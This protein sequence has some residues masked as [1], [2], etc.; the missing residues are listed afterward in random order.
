MQTKLFNFGQSIFFLFIDNSSCLMLFDTLAGYM[1]ADQG[2]D[3]WLANS[4][5]NTYSRSHLNLSSEDP[6]FWDWS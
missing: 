4:R 6:A 3:V 2:Y 5:G 1:M